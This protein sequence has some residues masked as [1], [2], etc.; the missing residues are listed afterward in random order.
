MTGAGRPDA[1]WLRRPR[2]AEPA[3][4]L[5]RLS[6]RDVLEEA[7]AGLLQRPAR[8]VL[9]M[10]GT[11]LGIGSF[12]AIV[13]LTA[14]T[15]GQIA[16]RFD[17]L[18]ATEVSIDDAGDTTLGDEPPI[19][20]PDDAARRLE[21]IDGVEHA[22]VWWSVRLA[23]PS[24]SAR[25]WDP[26][27]AHAGVGIGVTAAEPGAL[28]AMG[29]TGVRGRLYDEFAES[30]GERVAVL[31][32]AAAARLGVEHL[33]AAPAVFIDDVPYTV[34][35]VV[36]DFTSAPEQL[37]SVILPKATALA[38]YGDPVS[39][40]AQLRVRTRVGAAQVVAESTALALR[41][42]RPDLFAV[43]APA[44]PR[45]LREG[46]TGDVDAL[47]LVLAGVSLVIGALGIVNTTLVS[48]LERTP[49]IG[50]R[51]ALGA[52]PRHIAAQ[53]LVESATTG[54]VGGVVGTCLAV[55]VIVGVAL[56]RDL[57]AVLPPSL[58]VAA[59]AAGA[60]VGLLAGVYPAVRAARI[61]PVRAL[62]R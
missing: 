60:A 52:R 31:G 35:G 25:P 18:A 23:E 57:T 8:T 17:L 55:L 26:D 7:S 16:D 21:R 12:V 41:A 37:L 2:R 15:N 61:E 58:L 44:D 3:Q 51:R 42:D 38:E 9:T 59:P 24:I 54:A 19:S 43:H 11:V 32:R 33:S 47:F 46:V 45:T 5:P 13:G 62:Q 40:R 36:D 34:V 4:R 28:R 14:T 29:A 10:L 48:V 53:S 50:L 20:F 27:G 39:P 22:G 30:R 56:V 49:E 1:P 6:V